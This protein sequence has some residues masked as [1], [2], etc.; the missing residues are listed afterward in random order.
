M[1]IALLVLFLFITR[2]HQLHVFPLVIQASILL[3][4]LPALAPL[5]LIAILTAQL[6]LVPPPLI[7]Y[8]A[9]DICFIILP[10]R[11]VMH[12]VQPVNMLILLTTLAQSVIQLALHALVKVAQIVS[13]ALFQNTISL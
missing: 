8:P 1:L 7:A 4:L 3:P 2:P 11:L 13:L 6:A 9:L 10:Q 5:A 12:L